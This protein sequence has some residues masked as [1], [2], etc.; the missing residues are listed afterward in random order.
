MDKAWCLLHCA[1]PSPWA[2]DLS[3]TTGTKTSTRHLAPAPPSSSPAPLFLATGTP[4]RRIVSRSSRT[5]DLCLERT[6]NTSARSAS[7]LCSGHQARYPG[8]IRCVHCPCLNLKWPWARGTMSQLSIDALHHAAPRPARASR[9]RRLVS[10]ADPSCNTLWRACSPSPLLRAPRIYS[11][12]N[13]TLPPNTTTCP[14]PRARSV[15]TACASARLLSARLALC[16]PPLS[17]SAPLRAAPSTSLSPSLPPPPLCCLLLRHGL[18]LLLRHN[19]PLLCQ[20]IVCG[21]TPL[22]VL[23]VL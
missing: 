5:R 21:T 19:P 14:P 7:L 15:S 4:P 22:P 2:P 8:T 12:H 9:Q 20:V 6:C 23:H 18:R 16:Q 10:Q 3:R 17:C 11:R 13:K 1:R